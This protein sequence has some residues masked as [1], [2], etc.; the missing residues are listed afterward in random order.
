MAHETGQVVHGYDTVRRAVVCGVTEQTSSTKHARAVTC[1][2]CL[3][4][5]RD[6]GNGDPVASPGPA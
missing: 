3:E 5:L 1:P 6:R 4:I 2:A